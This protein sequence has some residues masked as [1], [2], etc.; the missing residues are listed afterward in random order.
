M[1]KLSNVQFQRRILTDSF[2]MY[3]KLD[4]NYC[5]LVLELESKMKELRCLKHHY[6]FSKL[7]K[8]LNH[9]F[10]KSMCST[11]KSSTVYVEQRKIGVAFLIRQN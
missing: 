8:N 3:Y 6:M 11:F 9:I 7:N 1:E 5:L 2:M 4:Y 10:M